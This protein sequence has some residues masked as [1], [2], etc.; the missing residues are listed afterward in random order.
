MRIF[1]SIPQKQDKPVGD[2]MLAVSL[3]LG[4]VCCGGATHSTLNIC[5]KSLSL[6]ISQA[7]QRSQKVIDVSGCFFALASEN[8]SINNTFYIQVAYLV[9]I[10]VINVF[11]ER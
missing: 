8:C 6:N 10:E 1:S 4:R 7:F 11:Y 5:C 9:K 3:V 2:F